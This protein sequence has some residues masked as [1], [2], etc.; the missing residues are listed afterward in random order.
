MNR[1][2]TIIIVIVLFLTACTPAGAASNPR[3]SMTPE[4]TQTVFAANNQPTLFNQQAA[5][6]QSQMAFP[7]NQSETPKSTNKKSTT[8]SG[9]LQSTDKPGNKAKSTIP[10]STP[11]NPEFVADVITGRPTNHSVTVNVV[12]ATGM[13]VYY[14]Y[15]LTSGSYSAQT[16]PQTATADVPLETVIDGLQSNTRYYYRLR[17]NDQTGSEHTFVTQRAPDS[18]FV[19]D[20][21]GDSHPERAGKQFDAGLYTRT[22]Q[23]AASDHPDFYLTIGDDFSVDTLKTVNADTVRQLYI[24]QRQWLG[25]VNAPVFLVNGNH[26]Q[27]SLANLNGTA[28][29][30]AVWAQTARNAYF[31]EPAPDTF[32]SGDIDPVDSIGLLRDYY[33]FTWGDVLF[34]VIDPYWHSPETVDNTFGADHDH[35]SKKDRDLWNVTL[36]DA[37]YQW[38]K[39]ILETSSAKY[40]FVFSHHVLGTG[41]GGI[42]MANSYE[43][44]DSAHLAAH[45]PGWDKTIQ[46]IMAEN[47]VT[48]FFQGHDHI[49]VRQELDGVIYQTLPE[50]ANPYYTL[51][52][53]DAYQSGVKYPNSGRVRVTV[54]ADAVQV[55]YVRSYLDRPDEL[56]YSYTVQ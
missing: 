19:F 16:E 44:G 20:I 11:A 54:S 45:R 36:G 4:S 43:W 24:H 30:V 47:R 7:Q 49:F 5:S 34:V 1:F 6:V 29:H 50:P 2:L 46:Q 33:S 26:E 18:S 28:D 3:V 53:A 25:L 39:H 42:E 48:I 40:K 55:D 27:A 10:A 51:E 14:E 52:N 56:A 31:P 38:F 22:L 13:N 32:Y 12:P 23:G 21:Q 17:S 35:D 37:Q 41:R 15:G 8:P 9:G